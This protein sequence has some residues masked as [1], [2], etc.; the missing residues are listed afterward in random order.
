MGS[1]RQ[2]E[3]IE[4][5]RGIP[6][7]TRKELRS[8]LGLE[9]YYRRFIPDFANTSKLFNAET[10]ERLTSVWTEEM[11]KSFYALKLKL[12]TALILSYP[13]YQKALLVCT[14]ASNKD[15]G[16]ALSQLDSNGREH[17]I[18]CVSRILSDTDSSSQNLKRKH[19]R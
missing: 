19:S 4:N 16:A 3:N 15:I 14:H 2:R 5:Q 13:D 11:Q 8:L 12:I 1:G 17:P 9:S 18:H 7:A 6:T 10:S